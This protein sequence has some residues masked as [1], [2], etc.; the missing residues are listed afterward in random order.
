MG[1]K[2]PIIFLNIIY[3]L[4]TGCLM[5]LMLNHCESYVLNPPSNSEMMLQGLAGVHGSF[6]I[7]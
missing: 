7:N 2:N 3:K 1:S 5:A 4:W 6:V